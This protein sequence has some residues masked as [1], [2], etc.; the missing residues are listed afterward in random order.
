MTHFHGT[1]S[2]A[3][4]F[5]FCSSLSAAITQAPAYAFSLGLRT[6]LPGRAR[7]LSDRC[8]HKVSYMFPPVTK[9]PDAGDKGVRSGREAGEM[10]SLA[11]CFTSNLRGDR[12]QAASPAE[13]QIG[14]GFLQFSPLSL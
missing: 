4:A 13:E 14:R 8:C 3:F 5:L 12:C 11:V 6:R 2:L 10:Q 9:L 7:S 1:G